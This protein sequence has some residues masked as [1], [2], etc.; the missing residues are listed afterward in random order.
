MVSKEPFIKL[1]ASH[2]AQEAIPQ[3]QLVSRFSTYTLKLPLQKRHIV[4]PWDGGGKG[5]YYL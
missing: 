5:R 2:G 1:V 4:L 3:T